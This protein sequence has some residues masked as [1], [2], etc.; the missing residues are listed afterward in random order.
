MNK[1]L[2]F[3]FIITL[4]CCAGCSTA[5]SDKIT[6]TSTI[7]ALLSGAYDGNMSCRQLLEHGDFG[8][9]TFDRLDGEMMV[10]GGKIYQIKSDGK[11]YTP[12]MDIK[13]PFATICNFQPDMKFPIRTAADY[14]AAVAIIDSNVPNQ[15][16]FLAVKISGMFKRM[17]VRSVPAQQKPYPLLVTVAKTQP[18]FESNNVS[19]TIIGFRFPP[20]VKGINMTGYHFHFISDDRRQGGHILDFELTSGTCEID[21]CNQFLLILPSDKN[22]L[23]GIDLS[24]DKTDELKKAEKMK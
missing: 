2:L 21:I 1:K 16:L 23:E 6:Q 4:A 22:W 14:K 9:G 18:V 7:D 17:K 10:L 24:R 5:V 19:G 12:A 11:I 15:N 8:V 3:L 13:T 20:Y